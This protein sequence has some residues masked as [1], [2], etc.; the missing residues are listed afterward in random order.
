MESTHADL[1]MLSAEDLLRTSPVPELRKL[2][3]DLDKE[4]SSKK[5][6]LQ[7]MVGSKY[8]DFIQSADSIRGMQEKAEEMQT[9][10]GTFLH[11]SQDLVASTE[12]LLLRTKKAKPKKISCVSPSVTAGSMQKRMKIDS[13]AVWTCLESCNISAAA[14]LVGFAEFIFA[15]KSETRASKLRFGRLLPDSLLVD[16]AAVSIPNAAISQ[17]RS[18]AFLTEIVRDDAHLFLLMKDAPVSELAENLAALGV[19]ED[20]DRVTLL[21]KLLA[22]RDTQL[23]GEG[24]GEG[25]LGRGNDAELLKSTLATFVHILQR[26]ILDVYALFVQP[27]KECD[28]P[29]VLGLSQRTFEAS[30]RSGL[31]DKLT[32]FSP[33]AADFKYEVAATASVELENQKLFRKRFDV[34]FAAAVERCAA[35]TAR[36][37]NAMDRAATVAALQQ[38]IWNIAVHVKSHS[39]YNANVYEHSQ[40]TWEAASLGLLAPMRRRKSDVDT[41]AAHLLWTQALR[42]PFL[43]HVERLL[44]GSCLGV[45]EK[46]KSH[47]FACF[48]NIGLRI[49]PSSLAVE[50]DTPRPRHGIAPPV[51]PLIFCH[52]DAV[53]RTLE[54]ELNLV[55]WG[56]QNSEGADIGSHDPQASA[57]LQRALHVQCAHLAGQVSIFLRCVADS[58]SSFLLMQRTKDQR[59]VNPNTVDAALY[60]LLLVGRIAW[61]VRARGGV[62]EVCLAPCQAVVSIAAQTYQ[63]TSEEQL[64]SAFDIADSNGDGRLS[65]DEALDAVLALAIDGDATEK[66]ALSKQLTPSVSFS[67]LALLCTHLQQDSKPQ[68]RYIDCLVEVAEIAHKQWAQVLLWKLRDELKAGLAHEIGCQSSSSTFMAL[69]I[70]HTVELDAGQSEIVRLPACPSASLVTF[71]NNL[72]QRANEVLLSID[73]VQEWEGSL[74]LHAAN[75][76]A[77]MVC[78]ASHVTH[79]INSTAAQAIADVYNSLAS[80]FVDATAARVEQCVLQALMDL[81]VASSAMQRSAVAAQAIEEC[82]RAWERLLDPINAQLMLPLLWTA[83]SAA[84][85][86]YYLLFPGHAPPAQ[87]PSTPASE[88]ALRGVFSTSRSSRFA[89]LPLAVS[90]TSSRQVSRTHVARGGE[91]HDVK[92]SADAETTDGFGKHLK[93]LFGM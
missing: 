47:V 55:L 32:E 1:K 28:V 6:E 48:A 11:S 66:I 46:V 74:S 20:C 57:A 14:R 41:V 16:I 27:V 68:E 42:Q 64:H 30:V 89:L 93:T 58:L 44:R 17:F 69:W 53:R 43:H 49:D 36:T 19:L 83:A 40:S 2:V 73:T 29:G 88:A 26:T 92:E 71:L 10:L 90:T 56:T 59:R 21:D 67:E 38:H 50:P 54:K 85:S 3:L 91:R 80:T 52:A 60:G 24:Q 15:A 76:R 7:L 45:L 81:R 63:L 39:V 72:N 13:G 77:G 34:W 8:H 9:K 86:Q 23:Q 65:Y 35:L 75:P 82:R 87:E 37:L 31:R 5:T 25:E 84:S 62:L 79:T 70:S 33:N 51:S 61:L 18:A 22:A 4:A 78:L 12:E